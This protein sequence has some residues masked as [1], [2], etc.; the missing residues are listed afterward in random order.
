MIRH[1]VREDEDGAHSRSEQRQLE[2]AWRRELE[3]KS[4]HDHVPFLILS[5]NPDIFRS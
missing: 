3:S 4:R 2:G 5:P 1:N